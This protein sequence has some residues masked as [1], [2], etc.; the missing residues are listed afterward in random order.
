[1]LVLDFVASR[2]T[3]NLAFISMHA[4]CVIESDD[5]SIE[6]LCFIENPHGHYRELITLYAYTL[7]DNLC[8]R[9]WW[10]VIIGR[11]H[12]YTHQIILLEHHTAPLKCRVSS[13]KTHEKNKNREYFGVRRVY[14]WLLLLVLVLLLLSVFA[15]IVK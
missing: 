11:T 2:M 13:D 4:L 7:S 6:I 12:T 1:M 5:F 8:E 9:M 10:I 14:R 3:G 15:V